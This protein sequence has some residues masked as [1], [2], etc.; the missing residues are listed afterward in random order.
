M[1]PTFTGSSCAATVVAQASANAA[2]AASGFTDTMS[3]S[4]CWFATLR[5]LRA[6][7]DLLQV[8]P[9]IL[10]HL[11]LDLV[12]EV[13]LDQGG[14]DDGGGHGDHTEAHEQ[15]RRREDPARRRDRIDVAVAHGGEAD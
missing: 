2:A 8:F 14:G 3:F 10:F 12:L 5:A 4:P 13:A 11:L 6:P 1:K 15:D 7:A 9:Q